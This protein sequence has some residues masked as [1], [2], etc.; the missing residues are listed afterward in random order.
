MQ[1]LSATH[2]VAISRPVEIYGCER[3]LE[4]QLAIHRSRN[5]VAVIHYPGYMGSA[6]GRDGKYQKLANFLQREVGAVVR[7]ANAPHYGVDYEQSVAD[8][9]RTIV[10]YTL[11]NAERICG[12]AQ[13]TLYLMG[14]SAG[15]SAVAAVAHEFPSV[16]RI[17]L[18]APSFDAGPRQVT[19]GLARFSGEVYII[20]GQKDEIVGCN[21]GNLFFARA[22]GA[23]KRELQMI[24]ECDH[25]FT[26]ERN[27]R[28]LSAS[29]LW[30]FKD[31]PLEVSRGIKLYD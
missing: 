23:S 31:Q 17:L 13:P 28:Y 6:D 8:D 2:Q 10:S 26:G 18:R 21:S 7:S 11:G 30:A 4:I 22:T 3:L 16:G 19:V 20:I 15:A 14:Y 24:A 25:H 5:G 1:Q 29:A 9:L 12:S 27:G